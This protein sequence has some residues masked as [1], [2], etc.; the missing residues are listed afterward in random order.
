M[1]KFTPETKPLKLVFDK[2]S[3]GRFNEYVI[4]V[5]HMKLDEAY[6]ML[7]KLLS[8]G[9]CSGRLITS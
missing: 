7:G 2:D 1:I 6:S 4:D 8:R 5:S 3:V 9:K